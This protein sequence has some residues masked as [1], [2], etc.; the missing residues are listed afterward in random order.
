MVLDTASSD[1]VYMNRTFQLPAG[2]PNLEIFHN[3]RMAAPGSGSVYLD[4]VFFRRLPDPQ[5]AEWT[6]L[7]PFGAYWRYR[8]EPAPEGW[9]QPGFNDRSWPRSADR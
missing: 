6:T 5:S 3:F 1:W 7:L 2:F 9:T 4:N 8:S